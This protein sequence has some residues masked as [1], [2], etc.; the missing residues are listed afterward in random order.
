MY[1]KTF[2]KQNVPYFLVYN[3]K[4]TE[5]REV[6]LNPKEAICAVPSHIRSFEWDF[7]IYSCYKTGSLDNFVCIPAWYLLLQTFEKLYE[8]NAAKHVFKQIYLLPICDRILL[9]VFFRERDQNP[10]GVRCN[11]PK[12]PQKSR[13]MTLAYYSVLTSR[14]QK[15]SRYFLLQLR[16]FVVDKETNLSSSFQTLP[17][18]SPHN[19]ILHFIGR[20]GTLFTN[21]YITCME[22]E[23]YQISSAPS[24][25]ITYISSGM[26]FSCPK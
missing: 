25:F 10:Q 9:L 11:C 12:I 16:S 23:V 24:S 13:E 2:L 17:S 7:S 22:I 1:G 6:N 19:V 26:I 3:A 18:C 20:K 14:V 21:Y 4:K 15:Y 5:V 8:W